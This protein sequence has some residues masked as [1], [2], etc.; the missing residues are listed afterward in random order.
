M[1]RPTNIKLNPEAFGKIAEVMGDNTMAI[2]AHKATLAMNTTAIDQLVSLQTSKED[3]VRD[4]Y[5]YAYK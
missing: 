2:D 5:K 3:I 1:N 4:A